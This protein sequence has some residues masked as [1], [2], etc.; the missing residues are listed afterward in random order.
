[1]YF[2]PAVI[3]RGIS[4]VGG[5]VSGGLFVA[6]AEAA[7]A[8]VGA[9]PSPFIFLLVGVIFRGA[10]LL[11]L[12]IHSVMRPPS[13]DWRL[14]PALFGI[15]GVYF[16]SRRL[17]DFFPVISNLLELRQY[18]D[19]MGRVGCTSCVVEDGVGVFAISQDGG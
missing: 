11:R 2:L 14:P 13:L 15:A 4:V 1:M 16:F 17:G 3:G 10:P 7:A 9:F 12:F 19:M 8:F 5:F 6:A 18:S